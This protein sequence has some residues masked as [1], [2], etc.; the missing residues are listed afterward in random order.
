M[1]RFK[2]FI[3]FLGRGIVEGFT[4]IL[5]GVLTLVYIPVFVLW[6]LFNGIARGFDAC[7]RLINKAHHLLEERCE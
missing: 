7:S 4:L 5:R 1:K 2:D 3:K 6:I